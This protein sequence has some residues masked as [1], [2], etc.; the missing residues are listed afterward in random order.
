MNQ[1]NHVYGSS[2]TII[3]RTNDMLVDKNNQE[4]PVDT[5]IHCFGALFKVTSSGPNHVGKID[6]DSY[7]AEPRYFH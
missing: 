3:L 6:D 4:I 7:F 5:I 1:S 2:K